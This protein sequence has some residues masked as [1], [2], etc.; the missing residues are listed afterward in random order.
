[1]EKT[2]KI[3]LIGIMCLSLIASVKTDEKS[4]TDNNIKETEQTTEGIASEETT[5]EGSA[6][7]ETTTEEPLTEEPTT[8]ELVTEEPTTKPEPE[9]K[10]ITISAAGDVTLGTNQK[11][12]YER[13]FHLY[14]DKYG[15]EYFLKKVSGVFASD[16]LTILNCEGVLT[17]SDN[18]MDKLWNHKGK[19]EYVDI[20]TCA[21]VEA[22]TLG[23]NHI[24]DYN[25]EGV[26]D[27]IKVLEE[28]GI[29]YALTGPWGNR[30]GF[31]EVKGVKVGYV[32]VNEH[33]D[34]EACY[35]WL[36]AGLKALKE[37][38][39][40][41][42]IAAVHWGGDYTHIIEP[43][44]Y[45]MGRWC[46]DIGYDLVL[47][48]H[49]HVLQGIEYYKDKYIVYS[50]GNFCYG[51]NKNPAEKD[52]MIFQQTFTFVDGV[53]QIKPDDIKIIP[54]RLSSS[55]DK[56]DYCPMIVTGTMAVETMSNLN[57]FCKEFG[58]EFD[59]DGY[60]IKKGIVDTEE[61]TTGQMG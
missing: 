15:K 61:V 40:D 22:V 46:I 28:A 11:Q 26:A 33:Y 58:T 23:N 54:C 10:T 29:D 37:R 55:A 48:S 20:L 50:L 39:A 30:Y 4:T 41:I 3:I 21:S 14:Y 49:P 16:D 2:V 27:T 9:V 7:E 12:G 47:G 53:L 42:V 60:I 31:Y 18:R 59:M 51:G 32:S 36:E 34:K 19:P 44:Q 35:P 45:D 17:E 6:S 56:N 24:M 52:T 13:S 1:M 8:E 25:E 57:G 38:G 5:T 43:E